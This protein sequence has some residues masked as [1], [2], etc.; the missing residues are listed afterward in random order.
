LPPLIWAVPY[1]E[2]CDTVTFPIFFAFLV[3]A[4]AAVVVTFTYRGLA[5]V[6]ARRRAA[7][8]LDRVEWRR[9]LSRV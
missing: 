8:E 4:L 1:T 7:W 2:S 3:L 5:A 6:R 9:W